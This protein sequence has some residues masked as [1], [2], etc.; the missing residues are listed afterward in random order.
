M[1]NKLYIGGLPWATDSDSLKEHFNSYGD[2]VEAKVVT[3]RQTGRSKGFGFV[4]FSNEE[5]AKK[6]IELDGTDMGG[7]IIRVDLA[8]DTRDD[9]GSR[10]SGGGY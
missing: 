2:V 3:D 4:T 1:G 9:G 6:A 10:N 8:K 7:R 5:E